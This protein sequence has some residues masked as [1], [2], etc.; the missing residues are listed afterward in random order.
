MSGEG[1]SFPFTGAVFEASVF[2]AGIT[3]ALAAT[4]A[5]G[6][7]GAILDFSNAFGA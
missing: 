1:Y 7:A 3:S 4:T 6:F 2:F 5:T